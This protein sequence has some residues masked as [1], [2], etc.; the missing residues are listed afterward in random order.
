[1]LTVPCL[2]LKLPPLKFDSCLHCGML[3]YDADALE[4]IEQHFSAISCNEQ[5]PDRYLRL[6]EVVCAQLTCN[7]VERG[8]SKVVGDSRDWPGESV[9]P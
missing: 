8:S 3:H 5:E 1:M 6:P 7:P 9:M 4:E 2:M